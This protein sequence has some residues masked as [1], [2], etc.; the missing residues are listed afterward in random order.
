MASMG[1]SMAAFRAGYHP[2]KTPVRVQ[3]AN[4][5]KTLHG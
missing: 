5:R 2:K 1:S 3:T 4:E